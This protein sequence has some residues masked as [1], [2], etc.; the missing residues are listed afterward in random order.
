MLVCSGYH[1]E[2]SPSGWNKRNLFLTVLE[3]EVQDPTRLASGASPL[4]CS[5]WMHP[6]MAQRQR[7]A[8]ETDRE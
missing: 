2:I 4:P 7:E 5:F 6:H 1:D 3:T 8:S